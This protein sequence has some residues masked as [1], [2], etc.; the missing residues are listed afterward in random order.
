MDM[1]EFWQLQLMLFSLPAPIITISHNWRNRN[2]G[3]K[4][5]LNSAA[6]IE[7]RKKRVNNFKI[8]KKIFDAKFGITTI[9]FT[10]EVVTSLLVKLL[11]YLF[12]LPAA[13]SE[14]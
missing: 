9:F 10:P 1:G 11:L 12:S 2:E 3:K 14:L 6:Q 8:N 4:N 5:P 7:E 13:D